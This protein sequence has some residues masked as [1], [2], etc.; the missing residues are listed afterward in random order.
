MKQELTHD[1]TD[2][3]FR[4]TN[5]FVHAGLMSRDNQHA[6]TW[7]NHSECVQAH[8]ECNCSILT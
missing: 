2:R 7:G 1:G 3:S 4:E 5:L 8:F 6:V